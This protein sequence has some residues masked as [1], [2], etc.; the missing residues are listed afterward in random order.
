MQ[1]L[2]IEPSR[3]LGPFVLG[4]SLNE[5]VA[6]VQRESSLLRDNHLVFDQHDP[7]S[8][9]V[10]LDLS[11]L[12]LRL[13]FSSSTQRLT[14]IDCYSPSSLTF[15]YNHSSFSGPVLP[16]PSL[17]SVYQTVGPTYPPYW[18]D[19][20]QV[21]LLQYPGLCFAFHSTADPAA[22]IQTSDFEVMDH[23][24]TSLSRL[25]VHYGPH[26][27]PS[28]APPLPSSPPTC[29]VHPHRGLFLPAL[30]LHLTFNSHVQDILVDLGPPDA[31]HP[32]LDRKMRI[33]APPAHDPPGDAAPVADVFYN[34]WRWGMD[35]LVDGRTGHLVKAVLH[36]NVPGGREF[37]QYRKCDWRLDLRR[38]GA[39]E[40]DGGQ[41][42]EVGS[43]ARWTEVEKAIK[44]CGGS[45][46]RGMLNGGG[47]KSVNPFSPTMFYATRG[48]LFEVLKSGY[49]QSLTL[50][51]DP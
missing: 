6:I 43:T 7:L 1:Q 49:V 2:V 10:V 3:S 39:V 31:L 47:E 46:S 34:Y 25:F 51:Q 4:S 5:V 21:Y 37:G 24:Q 29:V 50:F 15:R 32:R 17:S 22:P 40:G 27:T 36:N 41:V 8:R 12:S 16:P 26:V 20:C 28:P 42:V 14:L 48:V 45:V 38:R 44:E 13:R 11:D 35:L 18:D 23:T 33:H 19:E 9:D 30:S